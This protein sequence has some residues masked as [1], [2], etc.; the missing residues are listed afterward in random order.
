MRSLVPIA[1]F[2][3]LASLPT[4]AAAQEKLTPEQ[5]VAAMRTNLEQEATE[6]LRSDDLATV[7]WGAHAVVKFH[8]AGCVAELNSRLVALARFDREERAFAALAILDAL[9]QLEARTP[10]SA[11]APFLQWPCM[12]SALVALGRAEQ[13]GDANGALLELFHNCSASPGWW[14]A[15]GN[16]LARARVPEFAAELLRAPVVLNVKVGA[17]SAMT[18]ADLPRKV[19]VVVK[20]PPLTVPVGYPDIGFYNL[21]VMDSTQPFSPGPVAVFLFQERVTTACGVP[22]CFGVTLQMPSAR[23][24]RALRATWLKQMVDASALTSWLNSSGAKPHTPPRFDFDPQCNLEWSDA[25]E[26]IGAVTRQKTDVENT[27]RAL[28]DSCVKF[29]L[30]TP[31]LAEGLSP[32]I[33]F[34]IQDARRDRSVPLPGLSTE[35]GK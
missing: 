4:P 11:L 7:A 30:L 6:L 24:D 14:R 23:T 35:L 3:A 13:S 26:L 21:S 19:H 25:T 8:L 10:A 17:G 31:E 27:W 32:S 33:E 16:L 28:V 12:E 20:Q 1:V 18:A 34:E 22:F 9:N 5:R 29:G 2:A 15:C